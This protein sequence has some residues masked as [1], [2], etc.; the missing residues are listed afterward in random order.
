DPDFVQGG[1]H[2]IDVG[3]VGGGVHGLGTG[4][5]DRHRPIAQGVGGVPARHGQRRPGGGAADVDVVRGVAADAGGLGDGDVGDPGPGGGELL[6]AVVAPVTD[7][8][9]AV[10]ADAGLLWRGEL[11]VRGP[12]RA[13]LEVVHQEGQREAPQV[14]PAGGEH[15]DGL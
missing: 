7:Q 1:V 4:G 13:P 15:F 6:D 3:T 12:G 8:D 14:G 5:A 10:G 9:V 11:A 2:D